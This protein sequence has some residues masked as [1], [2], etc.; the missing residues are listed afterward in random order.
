MMTEASRAVGATPHSQRK[1]E[2]YASWMPPA[3][4][5]A[6]VYREQQAKDD[7]LK[8]GVGEVWLPECRVVVSRRRT[9]TIVDGP[10]F[11][12]YLF[13][14]GVLTDE[15]LSAV[16]SVRDVADLLRM[17]RQP[18]AA[19]EIQ[20]AKLQRL[21]A[22]SG[23]RVLIEQGRVKRGFG[24]T[25]EPAFKNGQAV[26]VVDGQFEGIFGKYDMADGRERV[27]ILLDLLGRVVQVSLPEASVEA[28][29]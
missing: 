19:C 18:I 24:H 21:M 1:A 11:P 29:A 15:W 26:R 10:L 16:L 22:E 2:L 12:G 14:R 5:V 6:C 17:E 8:L 3:W 9:R 28:V 7:L 23:G 20:M 13:V 27:K 25:D 4:Y